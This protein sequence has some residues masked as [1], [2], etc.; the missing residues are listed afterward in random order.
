MLG[1]SADEQRASTFHAV[2]GK[3]R[4]VCVALFGEEQEIRPFIKAF[5]LYKSS[6]AN[7]SGATS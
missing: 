4:I 6:D 5:S 7:L 1:R 3:H 2:P